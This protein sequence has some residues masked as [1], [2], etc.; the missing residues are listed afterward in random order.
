MAAETTALTLLWDGWTAPRRGPRPTLTLT[1]IAAS[2]IAVADAEGLAGVTMQRVAEG[3][4]VTKMAL[5]RYVPG[6]V[7]LVALMLDLGIGAP[8]ALAETP[9]GWRPRLDLWA[10]L[11]F[12][13][14]LAHPWA[15]EAIAG[16][17]AIGPNELGW[18]EQ[19]AAALAGTGL[20]GAEILDTAAV[21]SGHVRAI[22]QQ[23][24]A[25]AGEREIGDAM[26]AAL[27]GRADRFPAVTAAI[28]D[29]AGRDDALS[30]GLRCILDGLALRVEAAR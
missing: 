5:Y 6:K 11:L 23:A 26:A 8:P 18:M 15:A 9:G 2:G 4:G 27:A 12:A 1:A 13:R 20:T 21:L 10:R 25:G 14:F 3:L 29:P 28:A 22:A 19:A 24:A 7:E 17:R 30:F 16:E